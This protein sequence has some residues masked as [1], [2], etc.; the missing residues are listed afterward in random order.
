MS[1]SP[2][3]SACECEDQ[4]FQPHEAVCIQLLEAEESLGQMNDGGSLK[5]IQKER[6]LGSL[7]DIGNLLADL[8]AKKDSLPSRFLEGTDFKYLRLQWLQLA[9]NARKIHG[10]TAGEFRGL[11]DKIAQHS[12]LPEDL[13]SARLLKFRSDIR[14]LATYICDKSHDLQSVTGARS[15]LMRI[16]RQSAISLDIRNLSISQQQEVTSLLMVLTELNRLL[17]RGTA[18]EIR[19]G[20][21]TLFPGDNLQSSTIH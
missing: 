3:A 2:E 16:S 5:R 15:N 17:T 8:L 9:A 1:S 19:V 18:E 20:V 14:S 4:I 10:D 13:F 7:T 11:F 6:L 21:K 12:F